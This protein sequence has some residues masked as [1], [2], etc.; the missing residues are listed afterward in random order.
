M[1]YN[2]YNLNI[3]RFHAVAES[4]TSKV[5]ALILIFFLKV[6]LQLLYFHNAKQTP[7]II[8]K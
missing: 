2:R 6:I 7:E 1:Q 5:E 8:Q 4:S 3:A